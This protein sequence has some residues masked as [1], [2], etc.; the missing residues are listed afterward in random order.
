MKDG[1]AVIGKCHKG[2]LLVHFPN[3]KLFIFFDEIDSVLGL[4]FPV[5]D[6]FAWLRF[7]Y[8]QRAINPAYQRLTFAIFGVATPSD[9]IRDKKRTPF[10]IGKSIELQGFTLDKVQPLAQG[11]KVINQ[12]AVLK[13]ILKWTGGQPFLT[14]KLCKLVV[15]D[16]Q[17]IMNSVPT[18]SSNDEKSMF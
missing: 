14:Q 2:A 13:E 1:I 12:E 3:E 7:C 4:N 11:L 15:S 16:S 17:N 9:L 5:D 6:F 18:I 10:N 8:N